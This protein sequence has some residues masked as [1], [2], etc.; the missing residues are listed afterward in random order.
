MRALEEADGRLVV[1]D[2]LEELFTRCDDEDERRVRRRAP[3]RASARGVAI[4]ADFYGRC[5]QY[6]ELARGLGDGHV[7]VGPMRRDELRRAIDCLRRRRPEVE[8]QLVDALLGDVS[9]R[10]ARCRSSTTLLELWRHRDGRHLRLAAY[11]QAGGVD[12]AVARLAERAF[13]RLEP[14]QLPAARRVLLRLAGDG[15]A[16]VRVPLHELD[17]DIMRSSRSASVSS[18]SPKAIRGRARSAAARVAAAAGL[19]GGGRPGATAPS[20]SP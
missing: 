18:R 15:E 7:L 8:P 11:E 4:R 9:G 13:D 2:Q 14:E 16:A 12:G 19:A 5:A 3:R 17:D 6:P 10:P 1:V 20:A